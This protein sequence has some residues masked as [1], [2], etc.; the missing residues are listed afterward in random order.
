MVKK[1]YIRVPP[2]SM[3]GPQLVTIMKALHLT[4]DRMQEIV[5]ESSRTITNWRIETSRVPEPIARLMRYAL[6]DREILD[7]VEFAGAI[8]TEWSIAEF[9]KTE[10]QIELPFP[11]VTVE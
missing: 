5:G 3:S 7:Q 8:K 10:T 9:N 11:V 1:Q 4:I 6:I 2:S